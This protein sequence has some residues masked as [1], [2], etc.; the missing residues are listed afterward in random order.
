MAKPVIR[1]PTS[2][3]VRV[4]CEKCDNQQ[5][6]FNK[7]SAIV[8]CLNCG[9]ILVQPTGGLAKIKGKTLVMRG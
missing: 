8:K 6:V 1:L 7:A 5:I 9:E 3:F 2:K 4:T